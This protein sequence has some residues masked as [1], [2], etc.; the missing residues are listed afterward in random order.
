MSPVVLSRLNQ[1]LI[2]Q[3]STPA[4][5]KTEVKITQENLVKKTNFT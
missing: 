4:P 5:A 1:R 3:T 2:N